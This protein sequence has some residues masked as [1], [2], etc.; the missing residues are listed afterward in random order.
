MLCRVGKSLPN[1]IGI[2]LFGKCACRTYDSTLTA[3]NTGNVGKTNLERS[4]D[5]GIDTAVVSA[6]YA[7]ILLL[8]GGNTAA[9]KHA[10]II[11]P[12]KV[13]RRLVK[14][15]NRLKALKSGGINSEVTAELLK[16]TVGGTNAGK[17]LFVVG[18]K[19]EL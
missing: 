1:L 11:V 9:A 5:S 10:L 14:L 17:T 6:Y 7:Y 16:L 13:W 2:V 3:G 12:Y 4:A 19:N 15:V 8:A 18:R